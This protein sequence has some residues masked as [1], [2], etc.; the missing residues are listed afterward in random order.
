MHIL[1]IPSEHYVPR[2]APLAAIFQYQQAHALKDNGIKVGV[3]SAGFVPF[4]MMLSKYHYLAYEN[5]DGVDTYKC[6]KRLLIPGR[7]AIKVFWK[8][9]VGL[10][11]KMFEKYVIEQGMPDIIHAHNCLFAGVVALK[12]KEKYNIPY[13][14]T[15]HNSAYARGLVSNHQANL[16]KEV[17]K[18]ANVIT[19]VSTS[20]CKSLEDMYGAAASPNHVIFNILDDRF[21]KEKII[22]KGI[23]NTDEDIFTFL[24]IGSLDDNKNHTDLLKAFASKF[25]GN[26]RV[27]LKIGGD[28]P[29]RK[30]L[31]TQINELGIT[32]Q[33]VLT[34]LLSRD[35]VLW[36]MQNCNVFVL[37]SIFETFGVVL[38]E[39]LA[40]GKPVIATKCGGPEDIVNQNNGMLVPIKDVP[41]LAEAMSNIYI[42]ID[43]YDTR[44]VRNDCLSRFG[45]DY[46]V[47]RLQNI[48]TGIKGK[49]KRGNN[50]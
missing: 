45:K 34:G 28:G 47:E 39:A 9:L 7:V 15:E 21:E 20:L 13:L 46:F 6:Y 19:M 5:D 48:Y 32:G 26:S 44:F 10:Y 37:P 36:E 18:N 16:T 33:A 41:A 43:K 27:Q 11:L 49:G 8:Y 17:L 25:K 2:H 38:I 40:L 29:L 23:K 31:E 3:V 30:Q 14:I 24:S 50:G 22:F 4:N 35:K 1:I 12:I 42:N